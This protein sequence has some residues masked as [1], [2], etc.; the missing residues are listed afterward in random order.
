MQG[1]EKRCQ[2]LGAGEFLGCS[3]CGVVNGE[4]T[5]GVVA[6]VETKRFHDSVKTLPWWECCT[7][8]NLS[9]R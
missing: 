9:S 6:S 4:G 2:R 1:Q 5:M 3:I 7:N 8:N